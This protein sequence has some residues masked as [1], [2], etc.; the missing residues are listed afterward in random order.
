MLWTPSI[1]SAMAP[2]IIASSLEATV[3]SCTNPANA[4]KW[5]IAIA[6]APECLSHYNS[7]I[8]FAPICR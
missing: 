6:T 7:Y 2:L 4:R 1:P 5:G 3:L 8:W